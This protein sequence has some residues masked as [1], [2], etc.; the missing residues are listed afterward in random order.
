MDQPSK[1]NYT[2]KSRLVIFFRT[3]KKPLRIRGDYI[4][5]RYYIVRTK[6]QT[7]SHNQALSVLD[8]IGVS[9]VNCSLSRK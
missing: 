6:I 5:R 7:Q 9:V 8:A 1:H 4:A 2:W 3:E